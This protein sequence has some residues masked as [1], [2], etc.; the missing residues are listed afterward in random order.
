[1]L[2]YSFKKSCGKL[3]I[4][5]IPK[6]TVQFLLSQWSFFKKCF[7][8]VSWASFAIYPS[9]K[10]SEHAYGIKHMFT[11]LLKKVD[12]WPLSNLFL[13]KQNWIMSFKL[14]FVEPCSSQTIRLS[15]IWFVMSDATC[16]I[17]VALKNCL[18]Q[19]FWLIFIVVVI[20][21]CTFSQNAFR[22]K[23]TV[24]TDKPSIQHAN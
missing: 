10:V 1:M 19:P 3:N 14:W 15:T 22:K 9:L 8:F 20:N 2:S 18:V 12:V 11:Y 7:C 17:R 21:T 13:K 6:N 24:N 23:L 4:K 16:V 5:R